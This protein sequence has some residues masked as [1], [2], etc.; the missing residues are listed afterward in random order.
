MRIKKKFKIIAIVLILLLC[1]YVYNHLYFY[2]YEVEQSVLIN[3]LNTFE[4]SELLLHSKCLCQK[5]LIYIRKHDSNYKII[6]EN[7]EKSTFYSYEMDKHEFES[8]IFTCNLYNVLRR[9]PNQKVISYTYQNEDE[10][11]THFDYRANFAYFHYPNWTIRVYH[12]NSI[13]QSVVCEKQCLKYKKNKLYDNIDFCNVEE[14]PF[15]LVNKWNGAYMLASSWRWLPI[16]DD[17]V[18]IFISKY[19]DLC[20][21]DE[22][23]V[24]S[25]N[26]WIRSNSLFNVMLK[27][28]KDSKETAAYLIGYFN[29]KN[30][31][32]ARSILNI[33]TDKYISDWYRTYSEAHK[34][35]EILFKELILPITNNNYSIQIPNKCN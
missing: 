27:S 15:N 2:L 13:P 8:S 10:F 29:R 20:L 17:F 18:D 21:H 28:F 26:K 12:D 19:I 7:Q 1:F 5:D 24:K 35:D 34:P 22:D 4:N 14:M 33:I 23:D 30:R 9:G 3:Q 31:T 6:V 25:V 16:S 32:L 11:L